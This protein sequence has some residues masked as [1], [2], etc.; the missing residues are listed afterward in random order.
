MQVGVLTRS[1]VIGADYW[2]VPV[3]G[4]ANGTLTTR[5]LN[6]I[7]KRAQLPSSRLTTWWS[8]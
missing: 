7:T 8:G 6:L 5:C 1:L 3:T 2:V 4:A